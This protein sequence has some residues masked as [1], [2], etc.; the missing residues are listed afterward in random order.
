MTEQPMQPASVPP[1]QPKSS[2]TWLIILVVVLVVCCVCA[3][4]AAVLVW[5]WNNGDRIFD[6]TLQV[7][8]LARM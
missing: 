1:A 2:K 7:A 4:G 3:L 5:L 8:P 6:L